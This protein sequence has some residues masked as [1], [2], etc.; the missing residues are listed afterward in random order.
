MGAKRCRR[1]STSSGVSWSSGLSLSARA[2]A[3]GGRKRRNWRSARSRASCSQCDTMMRF[4]SPMFCR[5]CS[6]CTMLVTD[7][8]A[9]WIMCPF[10]I[11]S[12]WWLYQS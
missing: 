9:D 1:R 4:A 5:S 3:S 12:L 6:W 11:S 8:I 2:L 10:V 7:I